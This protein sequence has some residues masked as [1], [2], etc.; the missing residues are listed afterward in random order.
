MRHRVFGVIHF[1]T[2]ILIDFLHFHFLSHNANQIAQITASFPHSAVVQTANL[3]IRIVAVFTQWINSR[4][5]EEFKFISFRQHS[6][7]HHVT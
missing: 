6:P 2:L 1:D 7:V 3:L 4:W 5:N